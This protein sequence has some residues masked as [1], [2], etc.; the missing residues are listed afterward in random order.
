MGRLAA[1][2]GPAPVCASRRRLFPLR[3]KS[4]GS[5]WLA[6]RPFLRV[7]G[8][9]TATDRRE[10][11]GAKRA[12]AEGVSRQAITRS[13][14]RGA[15]PERPT[16][17]QLAEPRQRATAS[18]EALSAR[19]SPRT[20]TNRTH[21]AVPA[22]GPSLDRRTRRVLIA[23]TKET[24][25]H[26][27]DPCRGPVVLPVSVSLLRFATETTTYFSVDL[28]QSG[29]FFQLFQEQQTNIYHRK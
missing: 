19:R 29:I 9:L 17:R 28:V 1:P 18:T 20:H 3:C 26:R 2:L 6:C 24:D 15:I 25:H 13:R 16:V 14:E 4:G 23:R 8:W 12:R 21:R 27:P 10:P 7:A 5:R 11:G 22:S